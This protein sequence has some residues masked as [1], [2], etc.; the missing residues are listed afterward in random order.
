MEQSNSRAE[1][2]INQTRALNNDMR[3][4]AS[5]LSDAAKEIKSKIDLGPIVQEHPFRTVLI[6]AGVGYVLGGGMF[7][8]LTGTIVRVG[9]RAM[10]L[11]FLRNQ[12]FN[13]V[14]G[15]E[16]GTQQSI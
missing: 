16:S 13:L 14:A 8:P 11:P 4:L 6:A 12:L 15:G 5:E 3:G 7:T 10:L 9:A 2:V 1:R